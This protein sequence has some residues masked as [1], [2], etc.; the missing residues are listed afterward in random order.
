MAELSMALVQMKG[1][2]SRLGLD[3]IS[4]ALVN[5]NLS[6]NNYSSVVDGDI[7][8]WSRLKGLEDELIVAINSNEPI[9][10]IFIVPHN[11]DNYVLPNQIYEL[12]YFKDDRFI[13]LGQ[14]C[15]KDF[16]IDYEAPENSVLLLR[17]LTRGTEEQVFIY[18]N[19]QQLFNS[20]LEGTSDNF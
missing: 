8:S 9:K 2:K 12:F 13:S 4:I 3:P 14:K 17:N 10:N 7:L 5:N 1:L 19:G 11:D 16:F 18:I 6:F 15:A 20:D